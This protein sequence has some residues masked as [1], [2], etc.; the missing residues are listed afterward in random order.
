MPKVIE[1]LRLKLME[2]A[3]TQAVNGGYSA[4]TV[5]SVARACGV[6]TGTVY[7]YFPSKDAI[8]AA[9]MLADWQ[10]R[11][12]DVE[13]VSAASAAPE[14]V[15]R[16][17]HVQLCSY[18]DTYR[19]IFRDEGAVS[20]FGGALGRYHSLLREQLASPLQKFCSDGFTAL[21]A[22]EAMLT[23]TV[24]GTPCEELLS[25]LMKLF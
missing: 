13:A 20:G 7:N 22:A 15:L 4:V 18:L 12:A 10:D 17:I 19:P 14:P 8:F 11:M 16:C 25:I 3:K 24:S 21:F 6:G 5:R 1:N 23:W 2:E 9:F